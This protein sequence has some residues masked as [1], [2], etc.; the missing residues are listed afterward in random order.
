MV[1]VHLYYLQ[2]GTQK[3]SDAWCLLHKIINAGLIIPI[4]S[5]IT[6]IQT[7]QFGEH[8]SQNSQTQLNFYP[9]YLNT[10][11]FGLQSHHQELQIIKD[12]KKS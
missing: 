11:Y 5:L 4:K 2:S 3:V 1:A 12:S 9:R 6:A 8:L 7:A 10:T